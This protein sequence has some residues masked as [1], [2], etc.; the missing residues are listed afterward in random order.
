MLSVIAAAWGVVLRRTRS[1]WVILSAAMITTLLATTLLASGPIYA[2]AVAVSGLHRTLN[3]APTTDANEQITIRADQH[4][5]AAVDELARRHAQAAF[6]PTGGTILRSARSESF[7]LPGQDP[8][9]VTDLA[10]FSHYQQLEQHATLVDGNWPESGQPVIQAMLSRQ[11]ADLLGLGPGSEIELQSRREETFL[12]PVQV[13]G[14]F[15]VNDLSDPYWWDN[16]LVLDGLTQGAS[17]TTYGPF[18]VELDDFFRTLEMSGAEFNWR[19]FPVFENLDVAELP[20]LLNNVENLPGNLNAGRRSTDQFRFET[21]LP[22]ILRR[23]ERSLLVTRTG[24]LILSAQLAILAGYALTLTAGLLTDQRRVET[25]LLRSRGAG[26]GQVAMMTLMEGLLLA[27]PAAIAG[28]WLAAWSLRALNHVG[29]LAEINLRLDPQITTGAYLLALLSALACVAALVVPSLNSARTF[30]ESRSA[31]GR[32]PARGLGQQAGLD[33]LLLGGAAL[34]YWQLQRY[35]APITETVQGRLGFDPFLVAAPAI[36]ILAGALLAL[37]LIPLLARVV[38]RMAAKSRG[39]VSS[40]GAWQLAR[41]PLRYARAGLLLMLALAIGLFALSYSHTWRLSQQDQADYQTGA[42]VKLRPDRRAGSAIPAYTLMDAHLQL[43]GVEQSMPVVRDSVLLS[44]SAGQSRVFAA[45]ATV[46]AD[47]ISFRD[48]LADVPIANLMEQLALGRPQLK[49]LL[50]PGSPQ[51]LAI[52]LSIQLDPVAEGSQS[53]PANS[54]PSISVVLQDA[55]GYLYR[56]SAGRVPADGERHRLEMALAADLGAGQVAGVQAPLSLV[57]LELTMLPS[58]G[59]VQTG[60]ATIHRIETSDSIEGGDWTPV[61]LSAEPWQWT[62]TDFGLT[63]VAEIVSSETQTTEQFS[64]RF[65]SGLFSRPNPL[66][67]NFVARLPGQPTEQALPAIVSESFLAATESHVGGTLPVEIA[68]MR[69]DVRIVG[70]VRGFPTMNPDETHFIVTDLQT[71]MTQRYLVDGRVLTSEEWWVSAGSEQVPAVVDALQS[72]PFFSTRVEDRFD[73]GATLQ[74]DPVALGIIGALSL[75]FV[76]AILFAAI[77]FAVSAA[78][79]ARERLTEFAL[80]RALGLSPK[81]LSSWLSLENGLLVLISLVGGTLLGVLMAWLILPLVS[82]TQAA[83]RTMPEVI[84]VVPWGSIFWLEVATIVILLVVVVVLTLALR[85]VGLG[86]LLRL[87][88][89]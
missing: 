39:L 19:V 64:L 40:L 49:T 23:A 14:I 3:D 20:V 78:V 67:V 65:S 2:G 28:P 52:D 50:V 88:E 29:P 27:L 71:L 30:I 46:A 21:D 74:S 4:E 81:Q 9:D 24:V 33:L 77:G 10:I 34:G 66:P 75:G 26:N 11:A 51:I 12:V 55:K 59:E 70:S 83:A 1:D 5:F 13:S 35:G 85:R 58:R 56:V 32:Q 61:P 63:E 57:S 31:R 86:S 17:F 15:E 44:R 82:L 87:G 18:V 69:R 60:E 84:V 54:L 62:V 41:R 79:S 25:A 42:D 80:L 45:D 53:G 72:A 38:D 68:G 89:E 22:G 43:D 8:D 16:P 76:A 7:A 48:D 36:G 37:R 73:R 6:S 47:I